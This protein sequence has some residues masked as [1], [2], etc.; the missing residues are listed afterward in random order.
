MLRLIEIPEVSFCGCKLFLGIGDARVDDNSF[1]DIGSLFKDAYA[2]S[3]LD[4]S[5]VTQH[6]K[7]KDGK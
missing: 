3:I 6:K 2:D 1:R 4:K 7:K 5:K